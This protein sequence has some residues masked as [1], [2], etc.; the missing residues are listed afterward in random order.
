MLL[1]N[2]RC[3]LS[4]LQKIQVTCQFNFFIIIPQMRRVISMRQCLTIISVKTIK[5]MI[6][7]IPFGPY[8]SKPPFAKCS[9][10]VTGSFQYFS[11]SYK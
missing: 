9:S 2:V 6:V 4:G 10:A 5:T 1:N 8:R 11:Y 3:I 7:W